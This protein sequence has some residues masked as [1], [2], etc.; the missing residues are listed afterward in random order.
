MT[1]ISMKPGLLVRDD[2]G[3]E[4]IVSSREERPSEAWVNEQHD[5]EEIRKLDASVPWWGVMPLGGGL[6]IVP[7]PML[8][9]IR[10]TTYEDFLIAVDHANVAG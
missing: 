1:S 4:G 10:P 9:V 7:E 3:R 2:L 5:A 8:Q 6:V